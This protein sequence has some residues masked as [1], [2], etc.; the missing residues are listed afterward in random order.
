[1]LLHQ[2]GVEVLALPELGV[3]QQLS[4]LEHQ[5]L[6]R[7]LNRVQPVSDHQH[8]SVPTRFPGLELKGQ[9]HSASEG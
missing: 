8:R 4:L 2:A 7:I 5:D 9:N 6:V 3:V 1:M